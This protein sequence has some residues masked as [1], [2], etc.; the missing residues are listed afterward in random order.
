MARLRCLLFFVLL[1][2][3]VDASNGRHHRHAGTT[4]TPVDSLINYNV[5]RADGVP[6]RQGLG[7][8]SSE[9][10]RYHRGCEAIERCRE[11]G[12]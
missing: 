4:V 7:R 12:N 2:I 3:S 10:N 11:G 9:A 5:L 1:A 6:G 8:V